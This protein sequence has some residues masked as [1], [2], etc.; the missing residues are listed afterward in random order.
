MMRALEANGSPLSG[1]GVARCERPIWARI[2][3]AYL[4]RNQTRRLFKPI[5]FRRSG[6]RPG[7]GWG[8]FGRSGQ[9]Q[10]KNLVSLNQRR[11]PSLSN[12]SQPFSFC[13][14]TSSRVL[15]GAD[16][17]KRGG[18]QERPLFD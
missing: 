9:A 7:S 12:S 8:Q 15:S 17:A 4:G 2:T 10:R 18:R 14:D 1:N 13:R 6:A 5:D 16:A 3:V 11:S